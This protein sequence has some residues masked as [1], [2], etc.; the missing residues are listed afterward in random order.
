MTAAV[1]Q[2]RGVSTLGSYLRLHILYSLCQQPLLDVDVALLF[3]KLVE[4][5]TQNSSWIGVVHYTI[6]VGVQGSYDTCKVRS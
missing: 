5:R 6:S 3:L 1:E 4:F 2:C